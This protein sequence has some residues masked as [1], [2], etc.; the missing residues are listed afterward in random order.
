[1]VADRESPR[2]RNNDLETK[3]KTKQ[4]YNSVNIERSTAA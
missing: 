4:K 1:M 3:T 2:D